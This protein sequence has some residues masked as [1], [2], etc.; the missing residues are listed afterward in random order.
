[1]KLK[2]RTKTIAEPTCPFN[3][4]NFT[5]RQ[6]ADDGKINPNSGACQTF[7]TAQLLSDPNRL[8]DFNSELEKRG[9]DR[10][11]W[12]EFFMVCNTVGFDGRITLPK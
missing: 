11:W 4:D 9:I 10:Q 12:N 8:T 6:V 5:L 2:I 1:M 7:P 3:T